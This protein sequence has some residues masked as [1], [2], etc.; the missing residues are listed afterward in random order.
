MPGPNARRLADRARSQMLRPNARCLAHR[1]RSQMLRPNASRLANR[2]RSQMPGPNARR[3]ADGARSQMPRQNARC[4]ADRARSQTPGP[5]AKCLM[6]GSQRLSHLWLVDQNPT[7]TPY[8]MVSQH[9]SW[10]TH[11]IHVLCLATPSDTFGWL[12]TGQTGARRAHTSPE[13]PRHFPLI[14]L[15]IALA[16]DAYFGVRE[17]AVQWSLAGHPEVVAARL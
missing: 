9:A 1:A 8:F 5:N 12:P 7:Y 17:Q 15:F 14:P 10:Q 11:R 6:P 16:A 2:A 13:A 4:L 3:L